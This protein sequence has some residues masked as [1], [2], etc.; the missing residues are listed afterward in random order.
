MKI[1]LLSYLPWVSVQWGESFLL[2]GMLYF[3]ENFT[4]TIY[5]CAN[6]KYNSFFEKWIAWKI[7]D[8]EVISSLFETDENQT[9][10][11][12]IFSMLSKV[13]L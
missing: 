9:L 7:L 8:F 13:I 1:E 12:P 2:Y 10:I 6:F 11:I 3:Y 5:V 4:I